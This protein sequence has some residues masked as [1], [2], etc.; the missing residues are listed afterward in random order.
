MLPIGW[1]SNFLVNVDH[2]CDHIPFVNTAVNLFDIFQICVLSSPLISDE[3]R[4]LL[5]ENYYF[6]YITEDKQLRGCMF[7]SIPIIGNMIKFL[8]SSGHYDRLP[9]HQKHNKFFLMNAIKD[10]PQTIYDA[11]VT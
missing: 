10:Y 8:G 4:E 5:K 6:N 11:D 1:L 2:V 3:T 9:R 7:F